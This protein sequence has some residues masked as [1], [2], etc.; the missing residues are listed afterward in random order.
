[1]LIKKEKL[2][3]I[4]YNLLL[5]TYRECGK[6]INARKRGELLRKIEKSLGGKDWWKY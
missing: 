1:M 5:E 3:M 2:K 4:I 6:N